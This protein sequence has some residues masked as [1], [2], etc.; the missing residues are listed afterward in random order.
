MVF[1]LSKKTYFLQFCADRSKKF[2][3]IKEIYIYS[4]ERSRYTLLENDIVYYAM[5][6]YF[7]DI[8]V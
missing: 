4:S 3:P 2:K 8:S 5:T 6:D 1:K 7:G